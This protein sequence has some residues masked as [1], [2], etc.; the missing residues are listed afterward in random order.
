MSR[1]QYAAQVAEYFAATVDVT[2]RIVAGYA[3][4]G[5]ELDILPLMHALI[6]N[7]TACCLPVTSPPNKQL[8]FRR[9]Q[10]ETEMT[11]SHYGIPVPPVTADTLIPEIVLVPMVGFTADLHRIGYGAG[12]YDATMRALRRRRQPPLFV[13]VAFSAQR[14]EGLQA[15]PQ[16]EPLDLIITETGILQKA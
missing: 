4:I 10:G 9:W 5:E 7:G 3:P 13:G 6:D 16:D 14:V 2:D 11:R 1:L 12:Y 8:T 15:E